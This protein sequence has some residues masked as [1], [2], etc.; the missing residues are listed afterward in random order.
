V[1]LGSE[2]ALAA[3]A[4]LAVVLGVPGVLVSGALWLYGRRR[5]FS[6]AA[7]QAGQ[8]VAYQAA[9]GLV[10]IA[11]GAMGAQ[12]L[13]GGIPVGAFHLAAMAYGAFAAFAALD[14]RHFRYAR[15]R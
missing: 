8:A 4:H 9:L 15:G 14:G 5:R 13:L 1:G 12:A 11:L 10:M 7:D 3:A 6:F 2:R